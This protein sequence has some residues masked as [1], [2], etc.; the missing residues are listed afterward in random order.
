MITIDNHRALLDGKPVAFKQTRNHGGKIVPTAI[1]CHDTASGLKPDGD[2]AWLSGG[3]G[4]SPN[5]SAHC[6]IAR[7]GKITQLLDWNLKAWHAGVSKWNGKAN[8]NDFTIGIEIDNPGRLARV[9]PTLF[10]GVAMIDTLKDS[11]LKVARMSTP[12]HGDGWWLAYSDAQLDAVVGLCKALVAEY[13]TI[14]EIITHWLISP[15]RKMDTNPL[16]PLEAIRDRVLGGTD[17]VAEPAVPSEIVADATV[18]ADVLNLRGTAP[19]GTGLLGKIIEMLPKGTRL[20]VRE[21]D[22]VSKWYRVVVASGEY[23]GKTGFVSNRFV[24]LDK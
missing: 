15:G 3:P 1:V 19:A 23:T 2:I 7:D 11:S 14:R 10:S 17:A 13:P 8:C 12:A 21:V 5:S 9:S 24:K 22:Q 16:F 4:Q 18:V 6:V 20:D